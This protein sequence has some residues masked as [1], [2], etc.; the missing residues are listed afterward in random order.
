MTLLYVFTEESG[1]RESGSVYYARH[2]L[3]DAFPDQKAEVDRL[4]VDIL[5]GSS[6]DGDGDITY[7]GDGIGYAE[8]SL[9]STKLMMSGFTARFVEPS[10]VVDG[11]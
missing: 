3:V 11:E 9:V 2:L 7:A 6:V 1:G 10:F 5:P 4:L 8:L